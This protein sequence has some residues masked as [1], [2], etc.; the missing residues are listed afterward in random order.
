MRTEPEKSPEGLPTIGPEARK[1]AEKAFWRAKVKEYLE[2]GQPS[3]GTPFAESA[4]LDELELCKRGEPRLRPSIL[5][6]RS[7]P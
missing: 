7:D 2:A 4:R 3:L 5:P 6:T 1:L